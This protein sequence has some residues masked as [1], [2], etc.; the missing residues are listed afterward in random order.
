VTPGEAADAILEKAG[1]ETSSA[2]VSKGEVPAPS[3]ES[4]GAGNVTITW[5]GDRL[6]FAVEDLWKQRDRFECLVRVTHDEFGVLRSRTRINLYSTSALDALRRA[7]A[8]RLP[9]N[10]QARLEQIVEVCDLVYRQGEPLVWLDGTFDK[11]NRWLLKPLIEKGQISAIAAEGGTGKSLLSL[12]LALSVGGHGL[13][14]PGITPTAGASPKT[15]YCDWETDRDIQNM[16][17]QAVLNGVGRAHTDKTVAYVRMAGMFSDAADRLARI[18][19]D[20]N[21]ELA[22]IDSVAPAVQGEIKDESLVIQL[23]NTCRALKISSL[24]IGHVPKIEDNGKIIGSTFW[25]DYPRVSWFLKKTQESGEDESVLG[26]FHKKANNF[27]QFKPIGLRAE[28]TS[29]ADGVLTHVRYYASD[30]LTDP[31]LEKHA[32]APDRIEAYLLKHGKAQAA[33]ISNEIGL[34]LASVR[35]ALARGKGKRFVMFGLGHAAEWAVLG[36]E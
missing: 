20:E 33:A 31:D 28:F 5:P 22:V 18:I 7:L 26:L 9:I 36:E 30:V 21:I 29:D 15:L 35:K 17:Y 16:R 6:K 34:P 8:N 12:A 27:K 24:L 13:I 19:R 1:F 2:S 25:Y 11:S 14:V 10:W 3:F 32:P 23:M 4:D